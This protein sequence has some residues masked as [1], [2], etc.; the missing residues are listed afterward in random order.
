MSDLSQNPF[1]GS[2]WHD[3]LKAMLPVKSWI[4]DEWGR[5]W[6]GNQ[7]KERLDFRLNLQNALKQKIQT[8]GQISSK[9]NFLFSPEADKSL[10]FSAVKIVLSDKTAFLVQQVNPE[11]EHLEYFQQLVGNQYGIFPWSFK[12]SENIFHVPAESS[13]LILGKKQSA[14]SYEDFYSAMLPE[15][16][17]AF[18]AAMERAINLGEEFDLGLRFEHAPGTIV[19]FSCFISRSPDGNL[20]L[21]GLLKKNEETAPAASRWDE[22]MKLWLNSGLEKFTVTDETGALVAEFGRKRPQRGVEWKDGKRISRVYDFRNR[23]SFQVEADLGVP[24]IDKEA[25]NQFGNPAFK[26]EEKESG[27]EKELEFLQIAGEEEKYVGLTQ[28]VGQSVHALV[29]AIGVFDGEIFQWKTWWKSPKAHSIH[30]NAHSGEWIPETDWLIDLEINNQISPLRSWWKQED[31]PFE[32]PSDFG[33]GWMIISEIT[34]IRTTTIL[35]VKTFDPQSVKEKTA[36]ILHGLQFLQKSNQNLTKKDQNLQEEIRLK[37]LLIKEINHRAKNNLALAASLVKMEAGFSSDSDARNI[38]K[39]TQKRLETLASLHEFL[40]R[41]TANL[42]SIDMNIYLT[43]LVHGLVSS[44]GNSNLRLELQVDSVNLNVKR[45]N[46][47]GLLVNEL[48]SNA[49][50]HAFGLEK[51]KEGLLKV[52]FLDKG[53]F[54]KLRVSDNGPGID[55][56]SPQEDSLGNI[57]IEEFSKQ[58]NAK[59]EIDGTLGTTYLLEFKK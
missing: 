33:I 59:M 16:L 55:V 40:Y 31:L 2:G 4:A 52:D 54:I 7:E 19:L 12:L 34:G 20:L 23:P 17:R 8:V 53:E 42:D 30:A 15:T 27:T 35:A 47:V 48:V 18:V 11:K 37:D 26:S 32:I 24:A 6:S 44:F 57:L 29:A 49:F 50:K 56:A 45:A 9:N 10:L 46:T 5:I 39:N 25:E 22:N 13:L 14:V 36:H 51:N 38:L 21:R 43:T 3:V 28:W 1:S 41:E 58:L